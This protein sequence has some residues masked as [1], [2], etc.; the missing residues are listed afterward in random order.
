[1]S[2]KD[3]ALKS[4]LSASYINEI[5][6]GKK[7]PKG[8]KV[9]QLA[10][11]L[12]VS[13][14]DLI[15]LKLE[16]EL[17]LLS[18]MLEKNLIKGL[19]F[20]VFG[21]PAR[22]L[23]EIMA[24]RPKSFNA[25]IG[26]LIELT[27]IYNMRVEDF[28]EATLRAYLDM[29]HNYFPDL[30]QSVFEFCQIQKIKESDHSLKQFLTIPN[31]CEFLQKK[32]NVE[33]I[34]HDFA[35]IDPSLE[36]LH[37]FISGS[38]KQKIYLNKMLNQREQLFLLTREVAYLWLKL[39]ERIQTYTSFTIDSYEKMESNFKA[40]YF[41]SALLLP[42]R[43]IVAD[44]K[45]HFA[46]K[47]WDPKSFESLIRQYP[48]TVDS[49]F[50]RLTQILP[51]FLKMDH[52]F[53]LKCEYH[54]STHFYSLERELHLAG[55]HSPHGNKSQGHFCRRWITTSLIKELIKKKSSL[56]VGAQRSLFHGTENE[57][58][59]LSA[60][61]PHDLDKNRSYCVTIGIA[62]D[63]QIEKKIAFVNDKKIPHKVVSDNCEACAIKK[64]EVRA[65]PPSKIERENTEKKISQLI[66]DL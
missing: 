27:R 16:K 31:L 65:A 38:S 60:A 63:S 1:M 25:L 24:D 13:Y 22:V 49:F 3:L 8:E 43:S 37:L 11:S 52:I 4:T 53:F 6:K 5:E 62:V 34:I 44:V 32:Y 42:R 61:Y 66:K 40:S 45:K 29:N 64:C 35:T 36:T 39:K 59:C 23:F 10:H 55:L 18:K 19:P 50:H 20:D 33:V 51:S 41:A 7:Y 9:L 12:G 56:E 30:E 54:H 48:G 57:Y 14:E 21:I 17:A 47:T 28:F 15:S 26:T 46:E 58:L 2:L